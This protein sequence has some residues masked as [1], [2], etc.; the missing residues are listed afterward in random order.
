MPISWKGT[1][2][3]YVGRLH[4][5]YEGKREARVYDYVDVHVPMLERMYQRRLKGYAELGY[6]TL[7]DDTESAPG[8]IY[9]GQTYGDAFG[10]D[11]L[12]AGRE[13]VISAPTLASSRIQAVLGKVPEG[14]RLRVVT[15]SVEGYSVEYQARV[16]A[17][18]KRLEDADADIIMQPKLTQRYAVFDGAI[19]WYGDINFL[20]SAKAE[21]TAIRLESPELAGE[22]LDLEI[23]AG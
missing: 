15:R 17:A 14:V 1:L 11:V 22:L 20:S 13:I 16:L 10:R 21:D 4:R 12:A 8:M 5:N 19:V 2:A 6:Q 18:V 3:Q 7:S 9:T 23:D